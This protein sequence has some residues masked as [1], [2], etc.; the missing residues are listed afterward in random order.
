MWQGA[1]EAGGRLIGGAGAVAPRREAGGRLIEKMLQNHVRTTRGE[2][3]SRMRV[4]WQSEVPYSK[5][6]FFM[7]F[8]VFHYFVG[9]LYACVGAS[10][11]VW[12]L[13]CMRWVLL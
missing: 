9:G 1:P 2:I 3:L 13:I 8:Q 6:L 12:E 7:I 10:M 4:E 5:S 11:N